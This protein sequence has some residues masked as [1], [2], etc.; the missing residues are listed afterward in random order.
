MNR[1]ALPILTPGNSLLATR[2]RIVSLCAPRKVAASTI[3]IVR[4]DGCC[5]DVLFVRESIAIPILKHDMCYCR[6]NMVFM[7]GDKEIVLLFISIKSTYFFTI[8]IKTCNF[9]KNA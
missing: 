5:I 8:P 2:R 7:Q 3:S 1:Q 4:K 9:T 6:N